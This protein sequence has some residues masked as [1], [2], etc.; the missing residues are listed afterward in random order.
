MFE[1][2]I[3]RNSALYCQLLKD[4]FHGINLFLNSHIMS[5]DPLRKI[6]Y[7]L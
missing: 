1:H 2:D 7:I 6:N 5:P 3:Q 4:Q